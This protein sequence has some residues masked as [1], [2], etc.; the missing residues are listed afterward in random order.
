M[1]LL[2]S[3]LFRFLPLSGLATHLFMLISCPGSIH[4][5]RALFSGS[6]A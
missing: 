5:C 1:L 6:Q 2:Y 4:A 3:Q